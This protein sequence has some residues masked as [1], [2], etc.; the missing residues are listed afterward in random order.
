[1]KRWCS[2]HFGQRHIGIGSKD[3]RS[4]GR[5]VSGNGSGDSGG[6]RCRSMTGNAM[7]FA[8]LVILSV[9]D[10]ACVGASIAADAGSDSSVGAD[11]TLASDTGSGSGSGS[12]GGSSGSCGR[13]CPGIPT[14]NRV[15]NGRVGGSGSGGS[16]R[17]IAIATEALTLE[18]ELLSS[19]VIS[20]TH[21]ECILPSRSWQRCC[22]SVGHPVRQW[23]QGPVVKSVDPPKALLADETATATGKRSRRARTSKLVNGN[24]KQKPMAPTKAV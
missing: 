6:G 8:I 10:T 11:V 16:G 5:G 18:P 3:G 13:T 15:G 12:G 19:P 22:L 24:P 21:H 1:M 2:R 17:R 4:C 20:K 23:T 14:D 9:D 7:T